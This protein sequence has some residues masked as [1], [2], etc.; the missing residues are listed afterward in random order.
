MNQS[1]VRLIGPN[2]QPPGL[3]RIIEC[4]SGDTIQIDSSIDSV[5]VVLD[6]N[7]DTVLPTARLTAQEAVALASALIVAS[8]RT[9][10][11]GR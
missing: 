10:P 8:A 9:R 11:A 4:E 2:Q 5:F 3:P 6:D 1:H 7:D